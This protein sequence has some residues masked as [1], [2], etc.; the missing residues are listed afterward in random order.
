MLQAT[1]NTVDAAN[2]THEAVSAQGYLRSMPVTDL[3]RGL[4]AHE[5]TA[6]DRLL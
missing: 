3:R 4:P 5:Q 1:K 6:V 2:Q